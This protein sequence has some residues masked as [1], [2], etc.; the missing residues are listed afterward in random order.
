VHTILT[1]LKGGYK[2][3]TWPCSVTPL[4]IK[5]SVRVPWIF[6]ASCIDHRHLL[7]EVTPS[8]NSP[9]GYGLI[10]LGPS[11]GSVVLETL[12]NSVG[13]PAIDRIFRQ[14]TSVPNFI[15]VLLNR[16]NDTREAYTGEMTI[17]EV[18]PL[19]E[20]ISSQPKVPV[21]VLQPSLNAS[22]DFS[23]LLDSDGI[24][25]PDGN[26][27]KTTSNAPLAP[28]HGS[29]QLQMVFDTG[30][31]MPQL[32]EW[33]AIPLPIFPC[34][35]NAERALCNRSVVNAIYS[36]AKGAKLVDIAGFNGNTWVVHCDAE[37]NVSFKIGGRTY[38]IHPLDVTRPMM[39]DNGKTFCFGTV[40]VTSLHSFVCTLTIGH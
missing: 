33:V 10:G 26:A 20:N 18:L 28:S 32:P 3:Q 5:R 23:V 1:L 38:H 11:S 14:D 31:A 27:I 29:H 16:P 39:D 30:F 25:G 40:R 37:I 24:I 13:D 17:G 35:F 22:Q 34:I 4:K 36:G 9:E 6:F 15:S 19:F 2:Q 8:N 12:N 7:V 21:T